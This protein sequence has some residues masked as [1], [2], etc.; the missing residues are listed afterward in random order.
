MLARQ[1]NKYLDMRRRPGGIPTHELENGFVHM[2]ID[3]GGD[4]PDLNG[5]RQHLRGQPVR[6]ISLSQ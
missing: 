6:T 1:I 2:P 5:L 3:D 4:V